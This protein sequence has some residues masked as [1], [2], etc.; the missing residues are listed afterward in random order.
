MKDFAPNL[1]MIKN[2]STPVLIHARNA[3]LLAQSAQDQIVT[4]A[5]NATMDSYSRALPV[6]LDAS[7]ANT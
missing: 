3:M 6:L 2:S 5:L 1:A 7:L 4:N